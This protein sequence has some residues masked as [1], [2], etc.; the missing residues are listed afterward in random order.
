MLGCWSVA[1]ATAISGDHRRRHLKIVLCVRVSWP[2]R[3]IRTL[4]SKNRVT[5][6]RPKTLTPLSATPSIATC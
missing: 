3:C 1:T 4:Q 6:R 2:L 5:N